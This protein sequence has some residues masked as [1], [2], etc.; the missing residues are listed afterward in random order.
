[1]TI[2]AKTAAEYGL[3]CEL[4]EDKAPVYMDKN[5]PLITALTSVYR[6]ETGDDTEAFVMAAAP[7]RGLWAI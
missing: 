7:T 5:G 6:E 4:D 3:D 1:M 2:I